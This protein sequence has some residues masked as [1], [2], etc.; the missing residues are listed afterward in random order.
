MAMYGRQQLQEDVITALATGSAFV[1]MATPMLLIAFGGLLIWHLGGWAGA[2]PWRD[3]WALPLIVLAGYALGALGVGFTLFAF[4]PLRPYFLGWV[5]T[6]YV[7]GALVY[8]AVGVTGVLGYQWL[9]VNLFDLQ[10]P[11]EGWHDIPW[12]A[13]VLGVV[14][15]V[16]AGVW[17]FKER[18]RA[19]AA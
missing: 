2:P 9:G 11:A 1:L 15:A 7:A 16:V 14:G 5:V 3:V 12:M 17:W 18:P 19:E 13:G 8:G 4:R 10:S 6:G